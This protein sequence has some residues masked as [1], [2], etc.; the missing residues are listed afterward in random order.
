MKNKLRKYREALGFS[1]AGFARYLGLH[2]VH[3][4]AL[5]TGRIQ[6]YSALGWRSMALQLAEYHGVSPERL[7]GFEQGCERAE[8]PEACILPDEALMLKQNIALLHR[9]LSKL[10]TRRRFVIETYFG[11]SD[12]EEHSLQEI[13]DIFG[14][15]RQQASAIYRRGM[16]DL[17]WV[18]EALENPGRPIQPGW[19]DTRYSP[20]YRP[21]KTA[22]PAPPVRKQKRLPIFSVGDFV[23]WTIPGLGSMRGTVAAKVPPGIEAM[24]IYDESLRRQYKPPEKAFGSAR[25][26]ESYL[27][28]VKGRIYW[29]KTNVLRKI[30]R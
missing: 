1:Q 4:N 16:N 8:E 12:G 22:P 30:G 13:G 24:K 9:A 21:R 27:V 28:S 10:S 14:V 29:P 7:F 15:R 20:V 11:L 19:K 2:I 3:Y 25:Q 17:A 5:E 18:F 6:A 26:E 23:A